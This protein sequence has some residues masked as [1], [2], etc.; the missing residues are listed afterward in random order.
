MAGATL[1]VQTATMP[2]SALKKRAESYETIRRC[3]RALQIAAQTWERA[4]LYATQL[5][6][7]LQEQTSETSITSYV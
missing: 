4:N 7:L 5:M 6:C 3:I 1:L 2:E